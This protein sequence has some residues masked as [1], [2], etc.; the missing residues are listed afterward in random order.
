MCQFT[1]RNAHDGYQVTIGKASGEAP[2]EAFRTTEPRMVFI[3]SYSSYHLEISAFNNA[4]AS[5][6]LCHTVRRREAQ[7]GE[8]SLVLLRSVLGEHARLEAFRF[9][10]WQ[11]SEPRSPT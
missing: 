9:P 3:L 2:R 4:S 8:S 5:P 6:P 1:S 7:L 10:S 11:V